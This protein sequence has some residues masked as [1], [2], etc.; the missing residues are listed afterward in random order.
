MPS[1]NSGF[2]SDARLEIDEGFV[3]SLSNLSKIVSLQVLGMHLMLSDRPGEMFYLMLNTALWGKSPMGYHLSSILLHV[4]NVALLWTLLRRVVVMEMKVITAETPLI[5]ATATLVFAVHPMATESVAEVSFSSSLLVTFFVLSGLLAATAFR[6]DDAKGR[7]LFGGLG[8]FCALAAVLT[9]ESGIAVSLLMIVYWL[10]F[11]RR[12]AKGPWM[13]FL[14]TAL[15][16]T[17]A[18]MAAILRLA[19]ADQMKLEYL[20][21]SFGQVFLIQPQLWIFMIGQIL[22]PTNLAGDYTLAD[23]SLPPV[24]LGLTLLVV[25][26]AFQ[27]WLARRSRLGALGVAVWWI[28]LATVS[29]FIP[30]F[31][32]LADR[33][34]YLPLA[35]LVMQLSAVLLLMPWSGL[36]RRLAIVFS[37]AA[38]SFLIF[39]TIKREAVF[40]DEVS[41]WTDTLQKSPHSSLAHNNMGLLFFQ[42]GRMDEA[43]DEFE[44][45][46]ASDPKASSSAVCIAFIDI[47]R[48]QLDQALAQCERALAINPENDD[49]YCGLG[50]ILCQ[51]GQF[52]AGIEQ[53][54]KAL[55]IDPN[56][57]SSRTNL[58][59][60]LSQTGQVDAAIKQLQTAVQITPNFAKA[61]YELGN[62]LSRRGELEK[63][64]QQF[65]EVLQ[66][67]PNHLGALVDLGVTYLHQGHFDEAI[68]QF[69]QAL[70]LQPDSAII[71]DNL[72]VAL[73]QEGKTAD[74]I[75]QFQEALRLKPDFD[76][77]Q[78]NLKKAQTAAHP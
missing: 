55:A 7:F 67:K 53:F 60:A 70:Q 2:V 18:I 3:T 29:N 4:M 17:V 28:G 23:M 15:V 61:H 41:L 30:L 71:H 27:F 78:I 68:S 19:V 75:A 76:A 6:P 62:A 77:A 46:L 47:H 59:L 24:P 14:G 65:R 74:A 34:Y 56:D 50:I 48:G 11:R 40:A 31:A 22:W 20:G 36:S 42:Q 49:A 58:G 16:L 69:Q 72:G 66:I 52:E 1:L 13:I 64:A 5:L 8:I 51:R 21:G 10:L 26:V 73:I 43:T 37:L 45:A 9:K 32:I 25:I 57:A 35:G 38:I 33:F 44:Q 12:D 54:H 39:L 63:A